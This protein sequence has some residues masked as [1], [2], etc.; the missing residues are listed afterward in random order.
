MLANV[1]L[2]FYFVLNVYCVKL[3]PVWVEAVLPLWVLSKNLLFASVSMLIQ[4]HW[5][6]FCANL[7]LTLLRGSIPMITIAIK[8]GCLALLSF[9]LD[10]Y[11]SK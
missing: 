3:G 8:Q 5:E 1:G 4:W 7:I 2:L 9:S 6:C 11:I 10:L